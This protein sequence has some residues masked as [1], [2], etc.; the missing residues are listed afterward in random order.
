MA[1]QTPPVGERLIELLG[2]A[3]AADCDLVAARIDALEAELK[4]L[5]AVQQLLRARLG[6]A[7]PAKAPG[8][9]RAAAPA[10]GTAGGK[11]GDMMRERRVRVAKLLGVRGPLGPVA[12]AGECQIPSGSIT[13]VLACSRASTSRRP[14]RASA[15][16]RWGGASCWARRTTTSDPT[17][18]LPVT[19]P[20]KLRRLGTYDLAR[21]LVLH[22]VAFTLRHR[23]TGALLTQSVQLVAEGGGPVPD[24]A[25]VEAQAWA[26][27]VRLWRDAP[28]PD[29]AHAWGSAVAHVTTTELALRRERPAASRR[30]L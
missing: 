25:A 30:C 18:G 29:G 21:G 10:P 26:E 13:A 7:P 24:E 17:G 20:P 4:S 6:M 8:P 23:T 5:R 11:F 3:T 9:R 14:T 2:S 16:P 12:I 22:A 15:S 27:L 1:T 28:P 19:P